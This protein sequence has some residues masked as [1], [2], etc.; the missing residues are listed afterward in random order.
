MY[1]QCDSLKRPVNRKLYQILSIERSPSLE[2]SSE[3]W[4]LAWFRVA[5]WMLVHLRTIVT[6]WIRDSKAGSGGGQVRRQFSLLVRPVEGSRY[7]STC[8]LREAGWE[9]PNEL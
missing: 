8:V 3:V 6:I 7:A 4:D 1:G 9:C 2:I 5:S